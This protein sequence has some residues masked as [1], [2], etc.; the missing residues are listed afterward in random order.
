VFHDSQKSKAT[1]YEALPKI[2]NHFSSTQW[3][4]NRLEPELF[5]EAGK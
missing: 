1:L 4:M 2:L 3:E 5:A